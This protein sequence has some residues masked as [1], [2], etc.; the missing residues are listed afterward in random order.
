MDSGCPSKMI[1]SQLDSAPA[2]CTSE[3]IYGSLLTLCVQASLL[4][5]VIVRQISTLSID[6]LCVRVT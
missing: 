5:D 4:C 2:P 6:I 3:Q 1:V